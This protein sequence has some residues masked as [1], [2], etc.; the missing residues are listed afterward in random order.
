MFAHFQINIYFCKMPDGF[1]SLIH[2]WLLP[3]SQCKKNDIFNDRLW[4]IRS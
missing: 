2:A 4:K 3:C 1:L